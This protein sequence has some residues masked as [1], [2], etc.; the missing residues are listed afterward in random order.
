MLVEQKAGR[1]EIFPSPYFGKTAVLTTK[2]GKLQAIGLPLKAGIGL[3][4]TTTTDIDTDQLGTFTGEVERA[5]TPLETAI[6]KARLG[7]ERTGC[8]LGIATEGSFGPHPYIPFVPGH[9]EF[10]V[11]IDDNLGTEVREQ[12]LSTETNFSHAAGSSIDELEDFFKRSRFPSHGLIVRP[13][14]G[15]SIKD[16]LTR[17]TRAKSGATTV[18][19]IDTFA[20]L[21]AAI[22]SARR[23]SADGL[24]HIE[25]DMRA[26]MNPLRQRVLRTLA[27][28]LARRLRRLCSQCSCPGFGITGVEGSLSCCECGYPSEAPAREI[29]S[30]PKCEYKE[31]I[32]RQDGLRHVDPRHCQHCNP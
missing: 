22:E 25:T 6:R 5:G 17:L 28:K 24:A 1:Q 31:S 2:H 11:F 9:Q 10:I 14:A 12:I 32:P 8:R 18:K 7:M 13:N 21:H 30:C 4:I 23:K 16:K 20:Q 27:I 3:G 26:H 29:H 19:G 15:D